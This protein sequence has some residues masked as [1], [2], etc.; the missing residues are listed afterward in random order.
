MVKI[1]NTHG[2]DENVKKHFYSNVCGMQVDNSSVSTEAYKRGPF[3]NVLNLCKIF[4]R[5]FKWNT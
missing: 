5:V 2:L 1:R 4:F 3:V